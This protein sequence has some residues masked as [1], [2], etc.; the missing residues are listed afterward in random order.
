MQFA[1]SW[2]K[3]SSGQSTK[4]SKCVNEKQCTCL[5]FGIDV[6]EEIMFHKTLDLLREIKL[7]IHSTLLYIL[8]LDT[9]AAIIH[10]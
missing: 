3:E 9:K 4:T 1:L 2:L 10:N 5:V 7:I 6:K 8:D